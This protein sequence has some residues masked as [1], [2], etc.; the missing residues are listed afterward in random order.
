MLF[1]LKVCSYNITTHKTTFIWDMLYFRSS[2]M[3][4]NYCTSSDV[5]VM[6]NRDRILHV[7][8][9]KQSVRETSR[10]NC[11]ETFTTTLGQRKF[12]LCYKAETTSNQEEVSLIINLF[13][14]VGYQHKTTRDTPLLN[15]YEIQKQ[16]NSSETPFQ[17]V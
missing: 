14:Y 4:T 12:C 3:L 5:T 10:L 9:L 17:N 15:L 8:I 1:A 13:I 16:G 7:I 6:L 2:N 11:Y